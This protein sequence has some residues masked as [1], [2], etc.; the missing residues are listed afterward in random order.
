MTVE[1]KDERLILMVIRTLV[2]E[3]GPDQVSISV[4]RRWEDH[5]PA[6]YLGSVRLLF[7]Q[8]RNH[9]TVKAG[10]AI[11]RTFRL[12]MVTSNGH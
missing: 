11:S 8:D 4:P 3:W 7:E 12:E 5:I 2:E 1:M 6:G 10:S 9:I